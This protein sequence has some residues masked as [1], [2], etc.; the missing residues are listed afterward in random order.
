MNTALP[1]VSTTTT[2]AKSTDVLVLGVEQ[3]RSKFRIVGIPEGYSEHFA[4]VMGL[5]LLK[6]AELVGA[7]PQIENVAVGFGPD[8]T[9]LVFTGVNLGPQEESPT[10][11]RDA[12]GAAM[13]KVITMGNGKALKV[14]IG[15]EG[16]P[17]EMT[18]PIGEAAGLGCYQFTLEGSDTPVSAIKLIVDKET[19]SQAGKDF[20]YPT[21]FATYLARD[22]INTPA[23]ILTP[24][25]F[26]EMIAGAAKD[27]GVEFTDWDADELEEEGYGGIT[28]VGK[29]SVHKPRLLRLNY[30]PEDWRDGKPY[31][32]FVGKGVTFDSGGLDLKSPESMSTM[33]YDMAGAAAVAAATIAVGSA[34]LKVKVDAYLP[35][36]ENMPSG[37]AM[38]RGDVIT[39]YDG[40]TVEITNTDAEGRIILADAL[41]MADEISPDYT[42]SI[43]TLTGAARTAL[44]ERIGALYSNSSELAE[45]VN[46]AS[47]IM[48]EMLW[49][50]PLPNFLYPKLKSK[51]ADMVSAPGRIGGS[52]NAAAFLSEFVI[53]DWAH[54]DIAGPAW[55]AEPWGANAFGATGFGTRTLFAMAMLTHM[56][57]VLAESEDFEEPTRS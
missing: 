38:R 16:F 24:D 4:E 52:M 46:T 54:L 9:A 21:I 19:A 8:K 22:W 7:S 40:Q 17:P 20:P 3:Y 12:Y 25:T 47:T 57:A 5:P 33:K 34:N 18:W 36:V 6:A 55:A 35:L 56:G 2:L 28:A 27:V 51:V 10:T 29:G 44:G 23:N 50:M 13:R 41:A 37:S 45:M 42:I 26:C 32:A 11:L 39:M 1:E 43:A 53:G 48:G 49:E 15:M 31:I 14:A 30:T